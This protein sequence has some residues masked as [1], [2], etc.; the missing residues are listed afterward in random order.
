MRKYYD[1]NIELEGFKQFASEEEVEKL[2]AAIEEAA[3][4]LKPGLKAVITYIQE[5]VIL[6]PEEEKVRNAEIDAGLRKPWE[7]DNINAGDLE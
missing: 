6:T 1:A 4:R 3:S 7:F 2:R 5:R